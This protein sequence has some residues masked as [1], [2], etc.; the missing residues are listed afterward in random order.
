LADGAVLRDERF[1]W[2]R[3]GG[4]SSDFPWIWHFLLPDCLRGAAQIVPD[5][6]EFMA[7]LIESCPELQSLRRYA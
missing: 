2:L 4:L 3:L 7:N 1:S 5:S 6:V